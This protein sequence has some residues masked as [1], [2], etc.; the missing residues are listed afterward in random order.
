MSGAKS[1]K[2]SS[3]EAGL[4]HQRGQSLIE[5]AIACIVLVPMFLMISLLGKYMHVRQEAQ[6]SARSAAWAASVSHEMVDRNGG[7]PAVAPQ[8]ARMRVQQ[9]GDTS[10]RFRS[11]TVS[12]SRLDDPM[13]ATFAGRDLVLVKNVKLSR[14]ENNESPAPGTKL[15]DRLG[16]IGGAI[17][18]DGIPPDRRGYIT[19]EV[20]ARTEKIVGND[21][22]RLT[23]MDPLDSLDLDFHGKTV[24]LADTWD[25]RGSGEDDKG[26]GRNDIVRTVRHTVK[27][28]SPMSTLPDKLLDTLHDVTQIIDKIPLIGTLFGINGWYPG[29]TAPDIVPSDRLVRD[30][31][32]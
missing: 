10:T 22:S 16:A 20:N 5:M 29:K 30:G 31:R 24:L 15:I 3:S 14:Y 18:L 25:A 7:L 12:L 27:P 8:E 19:A 28:L 13:L 17:G 26:E 4:R 11:T 9:F 1:G 32:R 2:R 6:A 23:M 21:G